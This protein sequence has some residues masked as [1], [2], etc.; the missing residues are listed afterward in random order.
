VDNPL[1]DSVMAAKLTKQTPYL[2]A[3]RQRIDSIISL[4]LQAGIQPVLITQPSLYGA[5]IDSATHISVGN[6]WMAKDPSG[7]NCQLMEK[8]LELY[9][10]VL[11]SYSGKVPVIDLARLMPK[12]SI[13]FY[14]FVHVTNSGAEKMASLLFQELSPLLKK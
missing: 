2:A 9:N 14:D 8:V 11:R 12:Q 1:P 6:K 3:Y 4:C 5:Y 10:N 7:E 13:Y